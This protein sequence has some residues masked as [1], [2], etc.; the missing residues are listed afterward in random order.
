MRREVFWEGLGA[1]IVGWRTLRRHRELRKYVYL[2]LI[3]DL[4]IFLTVW[5]WGLGRIG[6][7]A[8]SSLA[9]FNLGEFSQSLFSGILWVVFF[10]AFTLLVFYV[11][12][13][14]SMIVASPFYA[15]LA[16]RTLVAKGTLKDR[17]FNFG[18]WLFFSLRM[19]TVSLLKAVLFSVL[20]FILF[21]FSFV[22][23][24]YPGSV[25]GFSLILAYDIADYSYEA[26]GY[27]LRQRLRHFIENPVF[28]I[29]LAAA[30]GL[31]TPLL[32]FGLVF[33]P[34]A[35]IGVGESRVMQRGT[36]AGLASR[37][38]SGC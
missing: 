2:P 14:F 9:G 24:L 11:V 25:A 20:G 34:L 16:E 5:G 37:Q 17:P 19:L 33:T 29:G 3:L 22:P 35:I 8:D 18:G 12:F 6:G 1:V 15:L 38:E 31:T 30:M 23:G 7:W 10:L 21:I 28:F 13:L 26:L 27:G 32:G 36:Q 4:V